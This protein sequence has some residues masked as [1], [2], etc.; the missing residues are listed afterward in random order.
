MLEL[1]K[2]LLLQIRCAYCFKP[3][4][5][6][7][8]RRFGKVSLCDDC[9]KFITAHS[10]ANNTAT[11]MATNMATKTAHKTADKHKGNKVTQNGTQNGTLTAYNLAFNTAVKGGL[12]WCIA[13]IVAGGLKTNRL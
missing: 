9:F 12:K 7:E 3:L 8:E 1:V 4:S 2:R 13:H 6:D 5:E 10:T 11:N